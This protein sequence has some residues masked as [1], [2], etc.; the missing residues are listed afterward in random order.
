MV[1]Q[2]ITRTLTDGSKAFDVGLL[3]NAEHFLLPAITERDA[4][5]LIRK[6]SGA[7]EEHTNER[8]NY[9]ECAA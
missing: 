4:D 7:V 2:K 6:I 9:Y 5:A 8:A 1:I 3:L